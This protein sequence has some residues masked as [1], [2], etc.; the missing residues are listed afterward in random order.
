MFARAL[1]KSILLLLT[2]V[3]VTCIIYP[4]ILWGIGQTFFPFQANGSMIY[5]DKNTLIGSKLI[6]QA[7]TQDEYFQPRPSAASYDASASSSSS[8]A[9]SNYALRDRVARTLG[10]IVK[11][12]NGQLVAPDI[13]KWFRKDTYQGKPNIVAQWATR[14]NSLAMAWVAADP[15]H[16][17]F[18]DAWTKNNSQ[19]IK[20]NPTIPPAILFF[21]TFSKEHPGQFPLSAERD[22]PSIFFNMW[23]Q[24]HPHAALQSVPADFV[25]TSASGLDPHISLDNANFQLDRIAKK[26]ATNLNRDPNVIRSEIENMIN[27]SASA[28]FVGL[29]GEKFVNVLELNIALQK[30]YGSSRS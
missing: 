6:A 19:L 30:R 3:V 16:S 2:L 29:A 8:L 18:V 11:Y 27:E 1:S 28:P 14:H 21:Q 22:I 7:F 9:A 4:A 24:D 17:A 5:D 25:T 13:E 23:R 12:Q 10:P 26:W 15:T 20:E